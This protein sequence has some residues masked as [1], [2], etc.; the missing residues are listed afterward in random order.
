MKYILFGLLLTLSSNLFAQQKIYFTERSKQFTLFRLN[1]DGSFLEKVLPSVENFPERQVTSIQFDTIN[2]KMYWTQW[3]SVHQADYNGEN[4]KVIVKT[5]DTFTDGLTIDEERE[6]IYYSKRN[7]SES[8]VYAV[9]YSGIDLGEV[10][11]YPNFHDFFDLDLIEDEIYFLSGRG[12]S[13]VIPTKIQSV[14]IDGS[15]LKTIIDIERIQSFDVSKT[16]NK[17]FWTLYGNDNLFWSNIEGADIDSIGIPTS[18]R[19]SSIKIKEKEGVYI[20]TSGENSSILFYDFLD[21]STSSII[22][23]GQL[24][25]ITDLELVDITGVENAQTGKGIIISPNPCVNFIDLVFKSPPSQIVITDSA[26]KIVLKIDY[27]DLLDSK[28]DVSDLATGYYVL[29]CI[30]DK[31]NTLSEKFVKIRG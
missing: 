31:G 5:G 18:N 8:G 25:S 9:S 3:E 14:N 2:S 13:P 20:G 19:L 29:T 28:L 10:I 1:E 26:G 21:G 27:E 6:I 30:D 11:T 24:F 22:N 7:E 12:S 15:N 16:E 23:F 4:E 17:I